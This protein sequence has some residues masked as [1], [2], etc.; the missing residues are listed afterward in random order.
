MFAFQIVR[1][2][3]RQVTDSPGSAARIA[4]PAIVALFVFEVGVASLTGQPAPIDIQHLRDLVAPLP[5]GRAA[6]VVGLYLIWLAA[7]LYAYV[8]WHHFVLLDERPGRFGLPVPVAQVVAYFAAVLLVVLIGAV[9]VY[10]GVMAIVLLA[11]AFGEGFMPFVLGLVPA[12]VLAV[13]YVLLRLLP[14]LAGAAIG[15]RIGLTGAWRATR[16]AGGGLVLSALLLIVAEIAVLLAVG[17]VLAILNGL[18]LPQLA[19]LTGPAIAQ[20]LAVVPLAVLSVIAML[21]IFIGL[22]YLSTLYG[23]FVEHRP[24]TRAFEGNR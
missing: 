14:A 21:P 8:G 10:A 3:V 1:H 6:L 5:P 23:Y 16:G 15:N 19:I 13:L 9:L 17:I 18:V 11:A 20:G 4:L 24:L 12:L 22:S 7:G 2:A